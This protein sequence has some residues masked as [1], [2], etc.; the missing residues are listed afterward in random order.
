MWAI[1]LSV[2][3]FNLLKKDT[4]KLQDFFKKRKPGQILSYDLIKSKYTLTSTV[5]NIVEYNCKSQN[6]Y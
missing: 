3:N 6:T 5:L 4:F 2:L 1:N